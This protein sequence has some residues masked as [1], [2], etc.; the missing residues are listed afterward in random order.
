M[1]GWKEGQ[2]VRV[3]VREVTPKDREEHRYYTHMAGL[4]GTVQNVY[5]NDE[6]AVK[7]DL[8][9]LTKV[10]EQVHANAT[11]RMR[12]QFGNNMTEEQRKQLTK[13]ELAFTPHYVLLV[14]GSDLESI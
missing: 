4:T 3:A 2:R 6:I 8:D 5:S 7:I 1:P 13:E 11:T 9:S 10:P 12:E 14:R